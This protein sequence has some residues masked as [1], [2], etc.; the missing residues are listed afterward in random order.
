MIKYF[1]PHNKSERDRL[2]RIQYAITGSERLDSFR[3]VLKLDTFFNSLEF[4]S[5]YHLHDIDGERMELEELE[6]LL[7]SEYTGE[8]YQDYDLRPF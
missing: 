7:F 2:K 8:L 3:P 1:F 6:A 4:V 5:L